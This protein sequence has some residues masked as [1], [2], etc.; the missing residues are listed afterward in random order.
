MFNRFKQI[1]TID[2]DDEEI[3]TFINDLRYITRPGSSIKRAVGDEF[4]WL[5]KTANQR[6][7]YT[8]PGSLTTEPFSECVTW[9][10]FTSPFQLSRRQVF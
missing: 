1:S 4:F 3:E 2:E 10:A 5:R 8:Y 6:H 7:Y 9:M